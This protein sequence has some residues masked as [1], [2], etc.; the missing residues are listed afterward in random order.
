MVLTLLGSPEF[1]QPLAPDPGAGW[2]TI[3][4]AQFPVASEAPLTHQSLFIQVESPTVQPGW[5]LACWMYFL[6]S[7]EGRSVESDRY[8]VPL[9][10]RLRL[11]QPSLPNPYRLLFEFPYWL[12]SLSFSIFAET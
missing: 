8:F 2:L 7:I 10:R 9:N 11:Y 4:P 1:S 5:D 6:Y 12:Q 3:D